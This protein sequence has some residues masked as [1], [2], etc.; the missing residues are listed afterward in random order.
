MWG[1]GI[2]DWLDDNTNEN[3]NLTHENNETLKSFRRIQLL[4]LIY[5]QF[6]ISCYLEGPCRAYRKGKRGAF[7]GV[8]A[9][10]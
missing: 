10:S 4:E 7:Q 1:G 2:P 3:N 6:I 5:M 9:S 8:E